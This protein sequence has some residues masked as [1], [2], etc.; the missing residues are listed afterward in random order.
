V[1]IDFAYAQ[2]RVQARLGERLSETGWRALESTLGLPQYLASVRN[3]S[4]ARYVQ[5]F[6]AALT[7]HAIERSLRDDWR[8]E[9]E[10]VSHWVPDA[11]APVVAWAAWLPY[12]DTLA[13]LTGGGTVLP[14][15]Q[16]DAVL[17]G[18]A[19]RDVAA[20]EL[21]ISD[22]AFGMLADDD[23]PAGW[24]ARWF[25]HWTSLYPKTRDDEKAGMWMLVAAIQRYF[26]VIDRPGNS[27]TERREAGE[28]LAAD[29]T[30]LVHR[31]AEAPVVV[32]CHLALVA[33]DLQRLRDGLLRR[34]L[35]RDENG[36]QAA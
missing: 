8:A 30:G 32:F 28:R 22:A 15:M 9:V 4:L 1:S 17:S 26:A 18:V 21:A 2:A 34:A 11:W 23:A 13:S 14:W 3:T 6:S 36:E 25:D 24:R 27:R 29:A 10:A 31:R 16:A 33:L 20:R 35:F 12:L 19:L 5:H 7:P